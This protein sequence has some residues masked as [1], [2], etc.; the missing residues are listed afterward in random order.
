MI[1][2]LKSTIAIANRRLNVASCERLV[3]NSLA[4]MNTLALIRRSTY[5]E[6]YPTGGLCLSYSLGTKAHRLDSKICWKTSVRLWHSF[7]AR[8]CV[9]FARTTQYTHFRRKVTN[10]LLLLWA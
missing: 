7:V 9:F 8:R 2:T 1:G 5:S 3:K 6:T 10:S 4:R